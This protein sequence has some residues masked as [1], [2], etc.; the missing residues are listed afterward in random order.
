MSAVVLDAKFRQVGARKGTAGAA[1][2]TIMREARNVSERGRWFEDITL[3]LLTVEPDLDIKAAWLWAACPHKPAGRNAQDLGVDIVAEAN[4]GRLIAVQR[5]CQNDGATLA[6]RSIDSF[7]AE[8][9]T[10]S[11]DIG[12]AANL[13]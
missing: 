11:I 6:K 2:G 13:E 10:R 5:K 7:M 4:D 9:G 1:L 12:M 3:L 8:A